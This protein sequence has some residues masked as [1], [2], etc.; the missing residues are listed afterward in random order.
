MLLRK[1]KGNEL[2]TVNRGCFKTEEVTASGYAAN[3]FRKRGNAVILGRAEAVGGEV[4]EEVRGAGI[5]CSSGRRSY[6]GA[7]SA[8]EVEGGRQRVWTRAGGGI[9]R[10]ERWWRKSHL[11]ASG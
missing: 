7:C 8:A 3:G 1:I 11:I 2:E 9:D 4:L 5:S 6:R 10:A